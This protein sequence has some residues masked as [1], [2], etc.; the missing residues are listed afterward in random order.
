MANEIDYYNDLRVIE[1][2]LKLK[3]TKQ[4]REQ[5]KENRQLLIDKIK[6]EYPE[7]TLN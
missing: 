3:M 4:D 7:L 1:N 6:E 5:L 2:R